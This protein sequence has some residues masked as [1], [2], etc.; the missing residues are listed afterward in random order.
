MKTILTAL[1]LTL[2]GATAFASTRSEDRASHVLA[3]TPG[4]ITLADD[5]GGRVEVFRSGRAARTL[6]YH[7]GA[8]VRDPNVQIVFLGDWSSPFAAARRI[9]LQQSVERISNSPSFQSASAYGVRTAGLL[10]S[11]RDLAAAGSLNDLRIQ[12]RIDA[13]MT[14]GTL[15]LR[16]D[17]AIHLVF[18]APR[19]NS[20]L[21]NRAG[22]RDYLSYHSHVQIHEVNV[23][24]AVVPFDESLERSVEA[25]LQSLLSAIINPD[26]DGWY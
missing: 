16:D 5:D 4:L 6:T 9:E 26:G 19:L 11:A 17:N 18:L 12:S 24:Y 20:T 8:V 7:G 25:A 2:A 21:G 10:V 1:T 22:G 3:P 23:R 13:A 15:P 14:A